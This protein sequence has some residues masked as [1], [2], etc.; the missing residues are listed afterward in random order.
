MTEAEYTSERKKYRAF[1]RYLIG[2]GIVD[3]MIVDYELAEQYLEDEFGQESITE[4][5]IKL[6]DKY[7]AQENHQSLLEMDEH[8]ALLEKSPEHMISVPRSKEQQIEIS[9]AR[10][11]SSHHRGGCTAGFTGFP[12][13]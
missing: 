10:S 4:K 5:L 8:K 6:R 1:V 12:G 2:K 3:G 13:F 9:K 7:P 11:H